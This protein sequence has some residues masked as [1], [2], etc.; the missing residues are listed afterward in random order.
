[1]LSNFDFIL[2]NNSNSDLQLLEVLNSFKFRELFFISEFN[3]RLIELIHVFI[4]SCNG[5]SAERM[6]DTEVKGCPEYFELHKRMVRD[7]LASID[8]TSC[9]I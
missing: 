3:I 1:M 9:T 2:F 8:I 5:S 7:A 6:L 4:A